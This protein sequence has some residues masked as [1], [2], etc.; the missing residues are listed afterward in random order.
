MN[1]AMRDW[2]TNVDTTYYIIGAI[3]G[4]HPYPLLVRDFQAIIG[5]EARIQH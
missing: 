5:K 4:L 3:A 1:E 2:V